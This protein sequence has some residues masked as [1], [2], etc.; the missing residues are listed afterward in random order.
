MNWLFLF[1]AGIFEIAWAIGLKQSENFTK[2]IPSLFTIVAMIISF[3]L[4]AVALRTIPLGVAYASW[5]GI[6]AVGTAI[7]GILFF[8][9]SVSLLKVVSLLFI[10]MGIVGLKM[11][12][13]DPY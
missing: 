6:G 10:V 12:S 3:Y 8:H 9:E 13:A 2:L 5:V 4:L 11:A 1:L 7:M